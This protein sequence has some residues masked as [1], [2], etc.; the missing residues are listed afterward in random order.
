M[1]ILDA[2]TELERE[3]ANINEMLGSMEGPEYVGPRAPKLP[4]VKRSM[5]ARE[6]TIKALTS[7]GAR[8]TP[9]EEGLCLVEENDAREWIRFD[10]SYDGNRRATL[11]APGSAAF[12]RLV[13]QMIASGFHQVEDAD[14]DPARRADEITLVWIGSLGATAIGT[15]VEGVRRCF[16]GTALVRV[17]AN[18][19]HDSYERLVEVRCEAGQHKAHEIRSGLYKLTDLIEDAHYLGIDTE[20]LADDAQRD[21]G[22]AEFRRFYIERRAQETK[23]AGDDARKR[24]KLED[25]FTPQLAFTVVA[26]EGTLHREITTEARYRFDEATSYASRLVVVPRTGELLSSPELGRCERTGRQAPVDCL[27]ACSLTNARVL[28]HLLAASEFT[29]RSALPEHTLLCSLSGKRALKD[30]VELSAVSGLTVASCLL[31]ASM[32]SGKRAEP[33]HFGRCAFTGAEVLKTELALSDISGKSYRLDQQVRS[34]VSGKTGYKE[35]F[36]QC[37]ETRHVMAPQEAEQCQAT[38]KLVRPGI[39][40]RCDVTG[41]AVLPSEL[42]RCAVTLGAYCA[43]SEAKMCMWGGQRSHPDDLRVCALTGIPIHV[44][45][46]APAKEPCLQPLADLLDGVRRTSDAR[47]HWEDIAVK[48]STALSGSRCRVETARVSPDERHLAIC[49][50]VRTLLGLRVHQAGLLYSID[51]QAIVGRI[52]MGKRTPKGW[53]AQN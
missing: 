51:E 5:D 17:R 47:E 46:V 45:F 48:V 27:G 6:F 39:L 37:H 9:S 13:S 16:E 32:L 29:G 7:L 52:A 21:P 12:S 33:E 14:D 23:A 44:E 41:K 31:K 19:A 40:E 35:E 30:E 36:I 49:S 15:K 11:Y 10:N 28:C 4:P 42:E 38:G 18:V 53:V 3:E 25:D 2:K 26:L 50:E 8:V 24:K 1:C 43:P 34:A 20:R 22:I